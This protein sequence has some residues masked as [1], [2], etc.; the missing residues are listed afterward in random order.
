MPGSIDKAR[1]APV[2]QFLSYDGCPLADAALEALEDALRRSDIRPYQYEMI[3]ILDPAT[4]K[5]LAN[6]GSPTILVNGKDVAGH[7]K[8]DGV[9]CRLYD[10]PERIPTAEMIAAAIQKFTD[11]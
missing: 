8:S 10:T 4:P 2:V 9:G 1:A 5:R 7:Q 11:E 3:D 6:W